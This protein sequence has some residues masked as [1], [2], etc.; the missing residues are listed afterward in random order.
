ML[1]SARREWVGHEEDRISYFLDVILGW[2]EPVWVAMTFFRSPTV[3]SG[4][5]F[6]RIQKAYLSCSLTSKEI[7]A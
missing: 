6:T 2:C 3:S 1:H 5:H 7:V 4:L